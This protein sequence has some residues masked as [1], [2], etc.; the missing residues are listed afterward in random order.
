MQVTMYL[1][2]CVYQSFKLY[3]CEHLYYT[4]VVFEVGWVGWLVGGI[5]EL[6]TCG[7]HNIGL[8]DKGALAAM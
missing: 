1:F 8:R 6:E 7:E 3:I 5:E 4:F 2:F